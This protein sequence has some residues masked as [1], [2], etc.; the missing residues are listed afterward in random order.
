MRMR[1]RSV[2]SDEPNYMCFTLITYIDGRTYVI[3]L[4]CNPVISRV[5]SNILI[6]FAFM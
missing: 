6:T 1:V 4:T 3:V 2:I 5:F